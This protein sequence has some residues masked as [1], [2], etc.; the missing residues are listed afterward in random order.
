MISHHVAS[1]LYSLPPRRYFRCIGYI[2]KSNSHANSA[3]SS[4]E[5]RPQL[6]GRVWQLSPTIPHR[7]QPAI[8]GL[9]PSESQS[10][11]LR[12]GPGPVRLG[13]WAS[14]A[15]C[16]YSSRLLDKPVQLVCCASPPERQAQAIH[17]HRDRRAKLHLYC[18]SISPIINRR[19]K[20]TSLS[21]TST[22]RRARSLKSK[23]SSTS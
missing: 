4:W 20:M 5:R 8:C 6:H 11:S 2:C 22:A 16:F 12:S 13:R 1:P 3:S 23:P 15:Q 14:K 18:P 9:H 17:C 21:S 7:R 10:H 19:G